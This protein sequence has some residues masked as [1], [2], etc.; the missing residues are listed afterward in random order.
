M[1][2]MVHCNVLP[3]CHTLPFINVS[4]YIHTTDYVFIAYGLEYVECIPLKM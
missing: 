4:I 1:A 2:K 3:A